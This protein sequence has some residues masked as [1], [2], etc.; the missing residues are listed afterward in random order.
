MFLLTI[1][2]YAESTC[3][4]FIESAACPHCAEVKAHISDLSNKYDLEINEI[5]I[6]QQT[7]LSKKILVSYDISQGDWGYVPRV[8]VGDEYCTGDV[9]CIDK[10]ESM[11]QQNIGA[12]CIT[13]EGEVE[14]SVAKIFGLAVADAI[15][16]CELAVLTAILLGFLSRY[17][18]KK[19]KVLFA[20][21][22]FTLAIYISYF[23][24]G[25]LI[26]LGF[27]SISGLSFGGTALIYKGLGLLAIILGILNFRD[28]FAKEGCAAIVE[29]PTSWRP[30]IKS[31]L[32]KVTSIP[33]AFGVG[34]VASLFLT[35]CTAGPY[36]VAGGILST[37]GWAS[38]IPWLLAYIF[39]FLSPMVALTFIVYFGIATAESSSKWRIR[40]RKNMHLIIAWILTLLGIAM[41][42]G[43]I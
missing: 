36:F 41:I 28:Y 15:N 43:F 38:A 5:I 34:F 33:G 29:M 21:L 20:G 8:F 31:M 19:H 23:V 13:P 26:I 16:P 42:L 9:P 27:K 37:L 22:A 2:A 3:V 32:K 35:P 6:E 10:L 14:I 24:F 39:V 1:P 18:D 25:L 7:E 12:E 17:P 40:N 30:K 11:I 4:Y